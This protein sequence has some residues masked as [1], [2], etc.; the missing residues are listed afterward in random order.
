MKTFSL[1]ALF[2]VSLANTYLL[3]ADAT[4]GVAGRVVDPSGALVASAKLTI[5]SQA[6]GLHR[7]ATTAAD[8]GFVFPLLPP[9][10]YNL[11]AEASGFRHYEQRGVTVPVN[12]TVSLTVTLQLGAISESVQVEGNAEQLATRSGTLSQTVEQRK[13][14]ELPLNGRNAAS[15]ILLT[16]A[17]PTSTPVT[18]AAPAIRR[19]PSATPV[20]YPSLQAAAAPTESTTSSTA[21]AIATLIST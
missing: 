20:R 17:R 8:G 9:G 12:V 7:D 5:T 18:P 3:A 13:I 16:P 1:T 14:V 15:L 2:A 21:A 4:G 11:V 6:T 10:A 19:S